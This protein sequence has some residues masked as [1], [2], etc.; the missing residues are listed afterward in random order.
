MSRDFLCEF[1]CVSSL[2]THAIWVQAERR[3]FG[4]KIR[5]VF[6]GQII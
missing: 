4:V 3:Y 5:L 6:E 1:F 2:V